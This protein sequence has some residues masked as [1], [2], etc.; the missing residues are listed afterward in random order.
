M[1]IGPGRSRW[2]RNLSIR[3]S[4][5]RPADRALG[6]RAPGDRTGSAAGLLLTGPVMDLD[7]VPVN[8]VAVGTVPAEPRG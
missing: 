6:F 5:N 2:G 8:N 1:N 7:L 3:I 4:W